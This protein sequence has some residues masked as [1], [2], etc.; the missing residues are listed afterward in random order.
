MALYII[1]LL[2]FCTLGSSN[3]DD[4]TSRCNQCKCVWS[5]GKKTADCQNKKLYDIPKDLS[6]EIR[7]IDFS[8]NPLYALSK[9]ALSNAEL[10][11]VHKIKFINCNITTMDE[12]ALKG[13]L[14]LI[15]L[16]MSRNSIK[17]LNKLTFR[18][19]LKLRVLTF[20]YNNVKRLDA[21]LFYN[22]THL[23]RIILNNNEIEAI[24]SAAFQLLPVL[25]Q[26]NLASN[27]LKVMTPDFLKNLPTINTLNLEN[28]PWIC[29]CH[30]QD[31]RN[32]TIKENLIT[33]PTECEAP[34]ALK[35]MLWNDLK[36]IFACVPQIIEPLPSTHIEA[37]TSNVTL[38]C[39]VLGDP[40]PDV[41]WVTNGR[42]ID[43]DP[44][45][46][47]QRFSTSKQKVGD[48]TWN[49]LTI[50]NVNYRDK[51]E[52]KCVA[53]NPGGTDEKNI[54]LSVSVI[55]GVGSGGYLPYG[56]ALPLIIG[57]SVGAVIIVIVIVILICCCCKRNTHG[58]N[59][60]R[61]D[62]IQNSSDECIRLHGQPEIEKALITDVNP[63]VKPPRTCSVPPSVNN[64]GT[65]V[66]EAKKNLLDSDSAFGK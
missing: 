29:D 66:S 32:K 49:N 35:G 23:Q 40:E 17:V 19:N 1:W 12:F 63:V 13:A 58:M 47:T 24:D 54:S 64:G 60:K 27:R 34:P 7:E 55:G 56:S 5:N 39:R 59:S 21:G 38:T 65:E 46:H 14:L 51:G 15:E 25:Q 3:D 41:D 6:P 26:I 18:D 50:T 37:T 61:R 45:Q 22:L 44:R 36:Q 10:R 4:W 11:N 57:L 9:E 33:A 48:Y 62:L 28:N 2:A 8:N 30:L 53:K 16:D 42:I 52:Y 43:R 31:F 20:S